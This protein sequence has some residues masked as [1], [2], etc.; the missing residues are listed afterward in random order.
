MSTLS[1]TI[2]TTPRDQHDHL[3]GGDRT[4]KAYRSSLERQLEMV[5]VSPV[6]R[7][8]VEEL[9]TSLAAQVTNLHGVTP[10]LPSAAQCARAATLLQTV[11]DRLSKEGKSVLELAIPLTEAMQ[12]I[13]RMNDLPS[14]TEESKSSLV[15][16]LNT[17]F[18]V[19]TKGDAKLAGVE[20]PKIIA[21]LDRACAEIVSP[22]FAAV[23]VVVGMVK[24]LMEKP[25][26]ASAHQGLRAVSE[27]AEA[28]KR[29]PSD[30]NKSCL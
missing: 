11:V 1:A 7:E 24:P 8:Q 10:Y 22:A 12:V 19:V 18:S 14:L 9:S 16:H 29:D 13:G 3:H 23:F 20:F 5:Q 21:T 17:V 30:A 27:R 15:N 2:Q 26:V 25:V 6:V 28:L 4:L